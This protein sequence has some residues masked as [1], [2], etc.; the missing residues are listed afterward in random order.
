LLSLCV[1]SFFFQVVS[2]NLKIKI[3]RTIILP[4]VLHGFETWSFTLREGRGLR[5]FE[6]RVL[7]GIFGPKRDEVTVEWRKLHNEELNDLYSSPKFWG[8]QFEKNQVAGTFSTYGGS[9]HLKDTGVDGKI[10]LRWIFRKWDVSAWTVSMWFS[11]GT[12]VGHL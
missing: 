1:K 2:K 12:G 11:I 3:N 5:V 4:V 9:G 7:R 8:D 6:N 10:I